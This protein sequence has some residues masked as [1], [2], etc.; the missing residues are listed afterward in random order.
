MQE[1]ETMAKVIAIKKIPPKLPNPLFESALLAIPLGSVI[2]KK[3]KKEMEK[4]IK[5]TKKIIFNTGLVE[6]LLKISGCTFPNKW[7]GT[8]A[9]T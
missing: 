2:S 8:L 3:P 1:N 9:N 5:I 4:N 7:N 6:M